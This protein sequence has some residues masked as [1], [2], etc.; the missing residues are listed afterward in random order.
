MQNEDIDVI[1]HPTGI[2][3]GNRAPYFVNM[4]NLIELANKYRK[5]LEINSYYLRLDL[6]EENSRKAKE[7]GVLFSI[8]TDSHRENNLDMIRLGLIL[9]EERN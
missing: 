3:F 8:D 2:V 7:S 6:D 4:E 9:Q 5:A 1:A